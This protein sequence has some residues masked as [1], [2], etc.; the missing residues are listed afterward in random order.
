MI[1]LTN[2]S[3]VFINGNNSDSKDYYYLISN[4]QNQ[5]KF[6]K[7]LYFTSGEFLNIDNVDNIPINKMNYSEFNNFCFRVVPFFVK[8]EFALYTQTDG[9]PLNP[10]LWKDEFFQYDYVGAPWPNYWIKQI[11]WVDGLTGYPYGGN[12]GF[13][14]RSKQFMQLSSQLDY[15]IG[16]NEDEYLCFEKINLFLEKSIKF[17]NIE[18]GKQFSLESNWSDHHNDLNQVFGFHNRDRVTEA[19]EIFKRNFELNKSL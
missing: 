8:T 1:N 17:S 14:L 19:K 2:T 12:G 13:S 18:I 16:W 6:H 4:L 9:F 15:A 5:I 10:H 3:C 11:Y 7:F